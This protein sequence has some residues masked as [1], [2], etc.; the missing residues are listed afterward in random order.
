MMSTHEIEQWLGTPLFLVP[1]RPGTKVPLVKYTQHTLQSTA[2]PTY[3]A[4][5]EHGNVAVRLG[6]HSG[7]FCAIDF[8]DDQSLEAFLAV[9]PKLKTTS[10]WRGRRGAQIGVRI[11]GPYPGPSSA[12][13]T[14]EMVEVNG[15]QLGRP[16]YEWRSIIRNAELPLEVMGRP[17]GEWQGRVDKMLADQKDLDREIERFRMFAMD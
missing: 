12:R 11:S 16:L 6:E 7:G 14:T 17:K 3:Q 13:S 2:A 8:D 9:N 10:R 5:L 15:R 4:L 1:C